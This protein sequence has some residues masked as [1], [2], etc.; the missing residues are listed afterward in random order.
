[1]RRRRPPTSDAP[2]FFTDRGLGRRVVEALRAEGWTLHPMYE[3]YPSSDRSR[4]QRFHDE[5][6]IP[7][8]TERNW[9][10]LSKDGFRYSHERQAIVDCRARVFMIPNASIRAEY[11]VER[12]AASKETIWAR[13]SETGPF[14]DAGSS[15]LHRVR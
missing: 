14:L 15:I 6:W 4:S 12:F 13:C 9:V 3:V 8:V 5:N 7:A 1:M 2:E 10:I 11:I